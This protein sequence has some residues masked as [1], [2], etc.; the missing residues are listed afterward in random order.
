M[1]SVHTYHDQ[2]EQHTLYFFTNVSTTSLQPSTMRAGDLALY[3]NAQRTNT[4]I[5][6]LQNNTLVLLG[7]LQNQDLIQA[8]NTS[9]AAFKHALWTRTSPTESYC[10]RVTRHTSLKLNGLE[11]EQ[12]VAACQSPSLTT[13][14]PPVVPCLP[15][16][17]TVCF[18]PSPTQTHQTKTNQ[19]KAE[20]EDEDEL[21]L[22]F[23]DVFAST[24]PPPS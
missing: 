2:Q 4:P 13:M 3:T 6:Q 18:F 14:Q 24:T 8:A 5:Y 1:F 21:E 17:S 23:N 11:L 7:H 16:P 19:N 20:A 12:L 22:D 10:T 9:V 15:S